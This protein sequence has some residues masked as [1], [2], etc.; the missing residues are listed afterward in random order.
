MNRAKIAVKAIGLHW[1]CTGIEANVSATDVGNGLAINSFG[2]N[3]SRNKLAAIFVD[4]VI[5][6][7]GGL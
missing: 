5:K 4:L 2:Q 3:N 6:V 1:K 7:L